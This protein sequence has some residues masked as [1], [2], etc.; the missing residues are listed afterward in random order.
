MSENANPVAPAAC[1]KYSD[2]L[3]TVVERVSEC[4]ASCHEASTNFQDAFVSFQASCSSSAQSI[5]A[6]LAMDQ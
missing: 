1:S 4:V 3:R 6:E 5:Q 2:F